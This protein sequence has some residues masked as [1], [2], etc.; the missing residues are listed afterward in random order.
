MPSI[1]DPPAVTSIATMV[2]AR[3]PKV[4]A[5]ASCDVHRPDRLRWVMET[6]L[7]KTLGAP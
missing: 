4:D 3:C 7:L 1:I 5:S 2:Y 6:S